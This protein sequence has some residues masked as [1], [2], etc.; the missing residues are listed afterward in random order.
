[1]NNKDQKASYFTTDPVILIV[2][3][4]LTAVRSI[5]LHY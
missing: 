2:M 4:Y 5:S 1:M 3:L